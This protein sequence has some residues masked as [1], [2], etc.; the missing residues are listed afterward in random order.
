MWEKVIHGDKE[1]M[2]LSEHKVDNERVKGIWLSNKQL[3]QTNEKKADSLF[4]F[5]NKQGR[6]GGG[7][8]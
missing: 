1:S 6:G 5:L 4:S 8:I 2:K 7:E 3:T